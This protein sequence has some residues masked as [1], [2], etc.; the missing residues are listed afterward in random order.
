MLFRRFFSEGAEAVAAAGVRIARGPS[1]AR[2]SD[3]ASLFGKFPAE[4]QPQNVF[5]A[6]LNPKSSSTRGQ[7]VATFSKDEGAKFAEEKLN[8]T[9]LGLRS[10]TVAAVSKEELAKFSAEAN[11]FVASAPQG[12]C[13]MIRD[14]AANLSAGDISRFVNELMPGTITRDDQISM[15]FDEKAK[16]SYAIINVGTELNA[17]RLARLRN[18]NLIAAKRVEVVAMN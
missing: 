13:V 5:F 11:P 6:Y 10:V 16:L 12:A 18:T 3:V 1:T 17:L 7:W 15:S 9:Y 14:L 2:R 4:Q 8:D